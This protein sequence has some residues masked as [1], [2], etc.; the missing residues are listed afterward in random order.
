MTWISIFMSPPAGPIRQVL[1]ADGE[2]ERLRK[3]V[4]K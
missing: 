1:N 2:K 4:E 3:G